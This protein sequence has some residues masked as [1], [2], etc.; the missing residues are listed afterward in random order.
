MLV[1][2]ETV[3]AI[4]HILLIFGSLRQFHKHI[5]N[6]VLT[7]VGPVDFVLFLKFDQVLVIIQSLENPIVDKLHVGIQV[8]LGREMLLLVLLDATLG[9][10][11]DL[12]PERKLIHKEFIKVVNPFKQ[13]TLSLR[14][15]GTLRLVIGVYRLQ[16]LDSQKSS[17]QHI[18]GMFSLKTKCKNRKKMLA[19]PY[20]EYFSSSIAQ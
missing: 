12:D 2:T 1:V 18:V 15:V 17:I 16:R 7:R 5:S 13:L 20:K 3:L 8:L 14:Q 10:L 11:L 4:I 6:E 19:S 9:K